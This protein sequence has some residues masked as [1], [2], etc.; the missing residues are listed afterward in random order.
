MRLLLAMLAILLVLTPVGLAQDGGD[1]TSGETDIP[2]NPLEGPTRV[3][4]DVFLGEDG[5]DLVIWPDDITVGPNSE[6]T[7]RVINV[8]AAEHDFTFL[9]SDY[10]FAEEDMRPREDGGEAVKTPLLAPGEEYD[11]TVTFPADFTGSITYIC[12]IPG[13]RAGG[14]EGVL[15]VGATGGGEEEVTDFGVDYLAYWVGIVSFIIVFVVLFGT[16]FLFRYGESKNVAD[17]RTG[18]PIT[19]AAGAADVGDRAAQE[20]EGFLPEPS[21]VAIVLSLIAIGLWVLTEFTNVFA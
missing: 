13:H 4:I 21:K 1:Q 3:T 9:T 8:G 20:E 18:A 6:V 10:E 11:L 19:A 14:M 7:F 16:F 2:E 15:H 12:S 5:A 17:H